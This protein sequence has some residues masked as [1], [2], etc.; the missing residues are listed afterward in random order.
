M[1]T[2]H[3]HRAMADVGTKTGTTKAVSDSVKN[4]E[5]AASS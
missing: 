3:L 5:N 1:I 4:T 2:S